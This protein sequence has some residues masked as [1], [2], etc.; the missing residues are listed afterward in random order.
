[1]MTCKNA[2][3]TEPKGKVAKKRGMVAFGEQAPPLCRVEI[4]T[5]ME[6]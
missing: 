2:E 5:G 6:R 1:M 4:Q 3:W